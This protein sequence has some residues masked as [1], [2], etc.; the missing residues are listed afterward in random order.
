MESGGY[1]FLLWKTKTMSVMSSIRI[2]ISWNNK[3]H[4]TAFSMASP[5][6]RARTAPMGWKGKSPFKRNRDSPFLMCK[7]EQPP[8]SSDSS[9]GFYDNIKGKAC[10]F[11]GDFLGRACKTPRRGVLQ[12]RWKEKVRLS[13][14][15]LS[16]K[17]LLIK[18]KP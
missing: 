14:L 16:Q 3:S 9:S 17:D 11:F 7:G 4:V 5:P 10:Q 13:F 8:L 2:S 1:F 12:G 6:F 18:V 15:F